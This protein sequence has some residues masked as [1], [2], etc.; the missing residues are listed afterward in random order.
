MFELSEEAADQY[1]DM[2]VV[3]DNRNNKWIAKLAPVLNQGNAFIAVGA[4]HLPGKEGL[5]S[6]LSAEGYKLTPVKGS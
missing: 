6:L 3:L 5:I 2:A 4:L 1:G